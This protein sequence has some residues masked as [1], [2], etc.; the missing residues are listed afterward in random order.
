MQES[1]I[2]SLGWED[3]LE[4]EMASQSTILA[5]EVPWTE[6]PGVL[7]SMGL[8][9]VQHDLVTKIATTTLKSI[10]I[11]ISSLFI[12]SPP[13]DFLKLIYLFGYVWS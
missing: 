13:L 4:K 6:K 7:Q 12:S 8:Q 11:N 10:L 3:P 2:G 1:W 9:R 5:W